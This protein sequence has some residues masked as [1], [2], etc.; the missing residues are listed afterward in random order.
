MFVRRPP[1]GCARRRPSLRRHEERDMSNTKIWAISMVGLVCGWIL[2]TAAPSFLPVLWAVFL[3]YFIH[4]IVL[5]IQKGLRLKKKTIAVVIALVLILLLL[6]VLLLF[7]LPSMISQVMVFVRE[8]TGYGRQFMLT[9]DELRLYLDGLGLDYRITAQVD[10]VMSQ[11][12]HLL[13]DIVWSIASQIVGYLFR[14]HP[15]L[16][17]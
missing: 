17:L 1:Y 10:D 14:F 5:R 12:F 9:V 16:H 2:F 3:A 7:I 6:S 15:F 4:P 13:S 8:F 11:I